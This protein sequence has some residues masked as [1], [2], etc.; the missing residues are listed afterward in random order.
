MEE[1]RNCCKQYMC[2]KEKCNFKSWIKTNN[3]GEIK[4][5]KE[6]A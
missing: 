4:Y 6:K 1:C 5:I 2:N 3:Y